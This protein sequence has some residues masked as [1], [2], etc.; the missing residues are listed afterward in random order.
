MKFDIKMIGKSVFALLFC[1]AGILVLISEQINPLF[2]IILAYALGSIPSGYILTKLF[3]DQDVRA[4]GSGS[5]G[6][7]NVLRTGNKKLAFLTLMLDV[8]KAVITILW[9]GSYSP[10]EFITYL[11]AIFTLLGNFYPLWLDFKGGKGVAAGIGILFALN[12]PIALA[13]LALWLIFAFTF[14]YSSLAALLTVIS[15]PVISILFINRDF[16][17]FTFIFALLITI[18]HKDNIKRLLQGKES[19]IGQR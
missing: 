9:L 17:I 2:L 1:L 8:L 4:I 10:S 15:L 6:A 16:A 12:W 14:K 5:I 7:T 11:I 13:A 3:T 18:R 19:K